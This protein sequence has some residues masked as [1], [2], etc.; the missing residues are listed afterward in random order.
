MKKLMKALS[1][2]RQ[3]SPVIFKATQGYGY[4]Y[5]DLPAIYEVITPLLAKHQL[6][7][8][9]ELDTDMSSGI[10][11]LKTMIMHLES[12]ESTTSV[13]EIPRIT[14]AK[15]NDYQS[16]GS[17]I[18]YFRRYCLSVSLGL[19]TDVDNDANGTQVR[20]QRAEKKNNAKTKLSV[21]QFNVLCGYIASGETAPN[22]KVWTKEMAIDLYDLNNSQIKTLN[23]LM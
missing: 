16:F 4:K 22:G 10:T 17:G 15:M 13:C 14:L 5:A 9:Q 21:N 20:Q 1:E 23:E 19:I 6:A 3:D 18:T 7:F 8:L 11:F 12:G 2:F